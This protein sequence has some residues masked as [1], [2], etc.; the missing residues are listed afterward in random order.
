MFIN[1]ETPNLYGARTRLVETGNS[2]YINS[3]LNDIDTKAVSLDSA[4]DF[5]SM[6]NAIERQ[7]VI[8]NWVVSKNPNYEKNIYSK[9]VALLISPNCVSACEGM[10][11]R[12]KK[13][14]GSLLDLNKIPIMENNPVT[15]DI[16]INY[17]ID[18]LLNRYS[19]YIKE[20]IT[21]L[22]MSKQ[23]L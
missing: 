10:A 6:K 13:T 23:V 22:K 7:Q 4:L 2:S 8:G 20:I 17:T 12:F 3:A 19:D 9:K 16:E 1:S 18:D 15:P 14:K 5:F 11:N 21:S